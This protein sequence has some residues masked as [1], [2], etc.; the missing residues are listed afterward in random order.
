MSTGIGSA[1]FIHDSCQL[2]PTVSGDAG[3]AGLAVPVV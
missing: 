1:L 2:R 3:N